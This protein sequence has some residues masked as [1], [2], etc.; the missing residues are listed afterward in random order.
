MTT[1]IAMNG[2]GQR[3]ISAADVARRDL[4]LPTASDVE[5]VT[6]F[7]GQYG[8][9]E[10][11]PYVDQ[12]TTIAELAGVSKFYDT[13]AAATAD[14]ANIAANAVVH[15]WS[16]EDN[17]NAR[18]AYRKESGSL[19][20]KKN[21]DAAWMASA[22][23][24]TIFYV[25]AYVNP[26]N[27]IM[28]DTLGLR[29]AIAA[30]GTNG[31]V[32]GKKGRTYTLYGSIAPLAGQTLEGFGSKI[33]RANAVTTTT[34]SGITSGSS[35][36]V[37][38]ADAS[39]F[40]VGMD[41]A[42][43][44]SA[45]AGTGNRRIISIVGNTIT[46]SAFFDATISSGATLTTSFACIE[47]TGDLGAAVIRGWELDGNK[48]NNSGFT[49]WPNHKEI[50][51][52]GTGCRVENNYVHDAV[53]EGIEIGANATAE[54]GPCW[55]LNN[56][57]EECNGNGIHTT[58][59]YGAKL[60]GNFIRNTNLRPNGDIGHDDGCISFSDYTGHTEVV[61]N[62]LEGGKCGVGSI[63]ADWNGPVT[64]ANNHI[65]DCT[66]SIEGLLPAQLAERVLITGNTIENSGLL[67]I[68]ET[69]GDA[70]FGARDWLIA[71]NIL[72]GSRINAVRARGLKIAGNIVRL[73]GDT[74]NNAIDLAHCRNCSVENNQ[75]FGGYAGVF[76]QG[77]E[78]DAVRLRS[79][80]HVNAYS[81]AVGVDG[82]V[83]DVDIFDP[84][85]YVDAGFTTA[86]DWYGIV[87]ANGTTIRGG[88]VKAANTS[89][90]AVVLLPN[91]GT[92][93]RGAL[94]TG[95]V[96][97]APDVDHAVRAFGGSKN[98]IVVGNFSDEPFTNGGGADNTFADNRELTPV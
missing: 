64:I 13:K 90:G 72:I 10:L 35:A 12:A 85:I 39:G 51:L 26:S 33:K 9:D 93:V 24:A 53:G 80:D 88:N 83:P 71:N 86:S 70:D 54:E 41:I 4:G 19:V 56:W 29:S 14:L 27:G 46:V 48:S 55:A 60:S 59:T 18:T 82:D 58:S 1:R 36:S 75:T 89:T 42:I 97:V 91:G 79:N 3:G 98:N 68:N 17:G 87:A 50:A 7:I 96:I 84:G 67:E 76:V 62:H 31:I 65:K 92:G 15:V 63:D 22:L 52:Y 66:R 47:N 95:M 6:A 49:R 21:L 73:D 23:G 78:T 77:S 74:T 81:R 61:G 38:V 5:A 57:I 40:R 8:S 2:R 28:A 30:A 34:T 37:T 16:D 11:Q 43:Q 25:E 20:F 44:S 69:S 45:T 32:R 94:V